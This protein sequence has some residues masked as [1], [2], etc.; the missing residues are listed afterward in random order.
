MAAVEALALEE[1]ELELE[2][3]DAV[4]PPVG[5]MVT[6]APVAAGVPPLETEPPEPPQA[7]TNGTASDAPARPR[8]RRREETLLKLLLMRDET[9][10]ELRTAGG[11]G[12][13][14]PGAAG[15]KKQVG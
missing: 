9:L 12:A 6:L 7:L 14:R 1:L 13:P 8:K 11:Y 15:L 10:D 4:A 5:V 3:D 2:A